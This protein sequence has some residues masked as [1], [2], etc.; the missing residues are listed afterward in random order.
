[1]RQYETSGV[2]TEALILACMWSQLGTNP[3]TECAFINRGSWVLL[4]LENG[5]ALVLNHLTLFVVSGCPVY[6]VTSSAGSEPFRS[7]QLR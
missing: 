6:S 7:W 5:V 3:K 1:M 2:T 4:R